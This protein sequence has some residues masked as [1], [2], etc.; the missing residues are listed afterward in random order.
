MRGASFNYL[1]SLDPPVAT[2]GP[3]LNY[4][5]AVAGGPATLL[6]G[7]VTNVVVT[8]S[9]AHS[10]RLPLATD[11]ATPLG[12]RIQICNRSTEILTVYT[13]AGLT[14]THSLLDPE[15]G[16]IIFTC[17]SKASDSSENWISDVIF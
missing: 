5:S 6:E 2:S 17:I 1:N 14:D 10:V 13:D 16:C 11:A 7:T 9:A 3:Y 4:V 12:W 15:R 8:G